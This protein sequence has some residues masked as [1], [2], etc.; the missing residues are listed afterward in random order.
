[1]VVTFLFAD[2]D[3]LIAWNLGGLWSVVRPT[4]AAV[5]F[6]KSLVWLTG[7]SMGAQTRSLQTKKVLNQYKKHRAFKQKKVNIFHPTLHLG[8]E[9]C[10]LR[11]GAVLSPLPWCSSR[12]ANCCLNRSTPLGWGK[13]FF[14]VNK[15]FN[16]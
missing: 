12:W 2:S 8:K 3:T 11:R 5:R 7:S 6:S 4:E 13:E 9:A 16:S 14:W 10:C 1:M 15:C